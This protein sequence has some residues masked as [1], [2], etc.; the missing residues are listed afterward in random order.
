[1]AS[2]T[3]RAAFGMILKHGSTAVAELNEV[4]F[5]QATGETADVT[6]HT[7]TGNFREKL[8]TV[9]NPGE[10]TFKGNL[11]PLVTGNHAVLRPFLNT[12]EAWT[13]EA[14]DGAKVVV[15]G[16]LTLLGPEGGGVADAR[17]ITGKIEITG[18][19]TW[20]DAAA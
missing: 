19:P 1:M 4:T 10:I 7:S 11:T 9:K 2:N 15:N 14:A 6:H 18:Q 16:I 5:P 20:T 3:A 12:V 13:V 17:M 8:P